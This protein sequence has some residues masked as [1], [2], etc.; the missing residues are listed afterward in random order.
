MLDAQDIVT[1]RQLFA[2]Q[3]RRFVDAMKENNKD[4]R[5]EILDETRALIAASEHRII[6]AIGEVLDASILPQIAELQRD[7]TKVKQHLQLA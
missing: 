4:L 2:E 6:S 5:I 7:M 1:L 3:D